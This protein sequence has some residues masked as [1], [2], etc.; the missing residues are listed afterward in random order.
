MYQNIELGLPQQRVDSSINRLFG[1]HLPRGWSN[2]MK[3]VVAGSHRS[4]YDKILKRLCSGC[5]LHVDETSVSVRGASCY[6]WAL[7][8]LQEVAYIY[9]PTREGDT[10]QA[11]L[12]DFSG[13]LVSDFYSVY[14]SINCPQQKCLIHLIRD[15]NE[16]T[17][18]HPYDVGLKQLVADFTGLLRSIVETVHR[19]GLKKR[20][21]GK[22]RS[23]V[24]RFYSR[25]A[26]C[27]VNSE[28]ASKL[29]D[30]L[31]KNRD[32]MF[33]FLDFNDVPWNNNNAEHAVKAFAT[34]RRI[35]EGPTTEKGLRE[36]LVL[37]S[38]CET[39]KCK[40][41]DFL[42]FLRSG[43]KDIDAFAS[44]QGKRRPLQSKAAL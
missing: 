3:A 31:Q 20:F 8:S 38:I 28:V 43:T 29:V 11:L 44:R 12:E 24:H 6:V 7:A 34:V 9:T 17:L 35:I 23:S 14:D 40:N 10:I 39:C 2:K 30:R 32:K 21:L 25:L 33:T 19:R 41:V 26:D 13:V 36:F 1:L 18:N 22:H 4:T 37:L 5:L 15:L 42:D 16:A 27:A